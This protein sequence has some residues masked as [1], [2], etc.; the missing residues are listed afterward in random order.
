MA[1]TL[2][3][4]DSLVVVG[5]PTV[6]GA[7]RAAKTLDWLCAHGHARLA[8]DAVVVLN[9][10][11]VSADVDAGRIHAYFAAR[12]RA[13]VDVPHDPHLAVGGRIDPA[14]LREPT[15]TAFLRLAALV[16]DGFRDGPRGH[17]AASGGR[18]YPGG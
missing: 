16:A 13:V 18:A 14:R 17:P 1:G 6:D 12:C 2:T 7:G 10:D 8:A 5:S 11:R 9:H 4:A 15:R 3:V